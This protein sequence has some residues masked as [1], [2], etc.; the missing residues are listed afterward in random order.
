MNSPADNLPIERLLK[1]PR[2]AVAQLADFGPGYFN[3]LIAN[4]DGGTCGNISDA[5]QFLHELL[6]VD[7]DF[8]ESM[9][10]IRL[11]VQTVWVAA[12]Y[13]AFRRQP[14]IPDTNEEP[15]P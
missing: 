12:Q 14:E 7:H 3:P 1:L 10:G 9:P 5:M 15:R 6:G 13:E 2:F 8:T 11:L 4:D